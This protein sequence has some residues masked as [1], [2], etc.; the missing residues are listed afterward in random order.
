VGNGK[1][2]TLA[3][4]R[5]FFGI[6]RVTAVEGGRLHELYSGTT[7]HGAERFR[8]SCAPGRAGCLPNDGP[9]PPQPTRY[10]SPWGPV[11]QAFA[12][13][14]RPTI[15]HASAIGLGAGTLSCFSPHGGSFTYYEI[16]KAVVRIARD[17]R[18][19]SFLR[20]CPVRA[21]VVL[22]DG[23]RSLE[24]AAPGSYGL[25]MVDAFNSDAIPIHLITREAVQ[26]YLSRIGPKGALMFHISNRYLDLEPVLGNI[27]RVLSLSCRI[28]DYKPLAHERK[29]GYTRSKWAMMARAPAD[30]GVV[31]HDSRWQRCRDAPSARTWT[32]DY[33]NPLSVVHWG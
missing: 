8:E 33:S 2:D 7:L 16:D 29:L 17:R 26:V 25:I 24:R 5:S 32:D 9:G 31:G 28:Q 10:Y 19:F 14:P 12:E 21:R 4:D 27:A 23:R 30:L 11:G 15:Q 18:L 13:L 6:Y 20:D 1:E 22:G 3:R